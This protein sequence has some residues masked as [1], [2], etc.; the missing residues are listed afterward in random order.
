MAVF[1]G[2][3]IDHGAENK[4]V[5]RIVYEMIS[6]KNAQCLMGNHELNAILYHSNGPHGPYRTHTE[7]NTS[8][9]QNFLDEFP[10]GD[11]LTNSFIDL[12]KTFPIAIDFGPFRAVHACWHQASLNKLF[13]CYNKAYLPQKGLSQAAGPTNI[14]NPVAILLKGPEVKLPDEISFTDY[15]GLSHS[16]TRVKWWGPSEGT[17]QDAILSVPNLSEIPKI[18]IPHDF[19]QF[20]YPE[21]EKP[22]I[23]GHYKM[24]GRPGLHASNVLCLDYPKTPCAYRWNEGETELMKK[25]LIII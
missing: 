8:Q 7:K 20:H 10:L 2:D 24:T 22:V 18:D 9:H 11:R 16:E 13:Y 12:F 19:S 6:D 14:E 15:N 17:L 23:I 25:N 1:L 5:L 3:L 4:A 21:T